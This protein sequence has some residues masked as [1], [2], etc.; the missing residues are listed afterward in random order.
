[1]GL[2]IPPRMLTRSEIKERV[3]NGAKTLEEVDP[4]FFEWQRERM[5]YRAF[6]ISIFIAAA[7]FV[8]ITF[9]GI[10]IK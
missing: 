8:L 1:M 4:E 9:I 2:V 3:K 6:M 7:W 10:M 5:R